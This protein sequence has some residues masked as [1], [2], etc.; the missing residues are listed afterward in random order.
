M[1]EERG[2]NHQI[3]PAS[4][5][6]IHYLIWRFPRT[7]KEDTEREGERFIK[8]RK[9]KEKKKENKKKIKEEERKE[10]EKG[11]SPKPTAAAYDGI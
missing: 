8:K 2:F 1:P 9:K 4:S 3:N 10:R 5:A 6:D 7:G 11:R